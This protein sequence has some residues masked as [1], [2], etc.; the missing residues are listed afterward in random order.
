MPPA[1]GQSRGGRLLSMIHSAYAK[2]LTITTRPSN[3]MLPNL[4]RYII[5][6]LIEALNTDDI[7]FHFGYHSYGKIQYICD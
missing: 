1:D 4:G 5:C 6:V 2:N 3:K 7:H